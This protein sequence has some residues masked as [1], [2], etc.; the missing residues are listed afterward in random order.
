MSWTVVEGTPVGALLLESDGAAL[1]GLWFG[2]KPVSGERDDDDP[3]LAEAAA[4]LGAYFARDLKEFDLPLAP[5]GTP[6]QLAVWEQLRLIPYGETI[7][8]GEL[9]RRVGSPKASR[10][11]GAANGRNPIGIVVPCHR[12]IG[13]NGTLTGFGGGMDAKRTLLDLESS[14]A[15]F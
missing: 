7:S 13:A 4:Q 1:T 14:T 15:L 8:Y 10:A 11:V 2:V 12:V 3:V 6:F 5:R 9:A